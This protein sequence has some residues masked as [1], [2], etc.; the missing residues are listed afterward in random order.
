MDFVEYLRREWPGI[1]TWAI[2]IWFGVEGFRAFDPQTP[3][4]FT[5]SILAVGVFVLAIA[6]LGLAVRQAVESRRLRAA[7]R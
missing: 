5:I 2:A 4:L 7:G 6:A 1:L 3:V